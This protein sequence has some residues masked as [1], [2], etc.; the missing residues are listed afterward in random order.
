MSSSAV[1]G[2]DAAPKGGTGRGHRAAWGRVVRALTD[3]GVRTLRLY[4]P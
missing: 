2:T 3:G 4:T 1:A